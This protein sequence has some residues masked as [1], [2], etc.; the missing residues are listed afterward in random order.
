MNAIVTGGAGFIG[1]HVARRLLDRHHRVLVL[2]DLS[3]G[4]EGNI[5]NGAEFESRSITDN[6]DSL[7]R[8]YRPDVLY[9][10][11]AY[12]AEGLSHHI[13]VY[14]YKNN[15]LGTANVLAAAYRAKASH[16][17]FTS[18]IAV[19]GHP[20]GN[21]SFREGDS[22]VPCDP[23]GVAKL[24][25][26]NHIRV[27]H[28]YYQTPTF[29]IFRPHNVFGPHQNISDPYR[30][31]IGIFL[32]RALAGEPLPIF[33][34]GAQTRSFSY[35]TQVAQCLAEAPFIAAAK[36]KVFNIGGDERMSVKDLAGHVCRVLGV[37]EHLIFQA[38]RMEVTHAHADHA[39]VRSVFGGAF[40]TSTTIVDGLIAMADY[41][42]SVPI[43][44]LTE[45]PS[46]IEITDL[47]P[48]AWGARL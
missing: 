3:G 41:V 28:D 31:V 44:E 10:F 29:T 47:L 42:R 21:D 4:S 48:P 27:F 17:V 19:Y 9:H 33:G 7:F 12:A 1:S 34:D 32:K 45:C 35:I 14:N 13:P 36:N 37:E 38:P 25:C 6:L 11:A 2:D 22:C 8:Q 26:E 46:E 39:L 30:N 15:L 5:P 16:F 43:P 20:P 23:Y 18:S 24:A 40:E